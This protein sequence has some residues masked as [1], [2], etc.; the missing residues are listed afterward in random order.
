LFT[1]VRIAAPCLARLI[2]GGLLLPS[3]L[4]GQSAWTVF[5]ASNSGLPFDAVNCIAFESGGL[6]WIG[7][8]GGLAA[9]DDTA[10]TVY[11]K[12]N[13][14]LPGNEVR[15][16]LADANNVIWI[17]TFLDGLARFDGNTWTVYNTSNSALPD[18][19]I[20]ALA[21]DTAGVKWIGTVAG[22][23]RF[24]DTTFTVFDLS[25]APFEITDNITDIHID[26]NNVFTVGTLNGG[27]IRI[28]DTAWTVYTIPNG[29]GIPDNTQLEVAVD[30]NGVEWMA[31]PSNGL[32]A[33]P[34]PQIWLAYTPFTSTMPSYGATSLEIMTNPGRIWVG[35]IDKGIV[36]KTGSAFAYFDPTN[37]PFP[38]SHVTCVEHDDAG[39]MWIGTSMKGLV[40]LDENLL[41]GIDGPAGDSPKVYPN[42]AGKSLHVGG[43]AAVRRPVLSD[44]AGKVIDV[45]A[46]RVGDGWVMNLTDIR[47]GMYL[48]RLLAG[49]GRR[50]T[51]KI[52]RSD[53]MQ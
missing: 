50:S 2:A 15:S 4:F 40:R 17:G 42:P 30:S 45:Q 53:S 25:N 52:I 18:N 51:V 3:I 20:K 49:D 39:R 46:S 7:T 28:V 9:F 38:D 26:S 48:L 19:Q 14:G 21:V 47:P 5:D 32:V 44:P 33:H 41:T 43:A 27:L 12:A 36:R 10:W 29:S 35:T 11:T 22:L 13:S 31:T 16:L 37:S 34:G 24:D 6:K 8:E 1:D 23:V